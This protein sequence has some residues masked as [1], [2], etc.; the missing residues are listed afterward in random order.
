MY[1]DTKDLEL[2]A[3]KFSDRLLDGRICYY[4]K[5]DDNGYKANAVHAGIIWSREVIAELNRRNYDEVSELQT[6][7]LLLLIFYVR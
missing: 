3:K 2:F 4:L 5:K 1:L 6:S 7:D